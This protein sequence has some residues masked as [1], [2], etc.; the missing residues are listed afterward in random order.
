MVMLM[1]QATSCEAY[2]RCGAKSRVVWRDGAKCCDVLR[3]L[4]FWI[5]GLPTGP[6]VVRLLQLWSRRR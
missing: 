4:L 2:R 1:V 3:L 6:K 5:E